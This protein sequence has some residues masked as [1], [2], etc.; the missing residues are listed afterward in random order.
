MSI[1]IFI[2]LSSKKLINQSKVL[3]TYCYVKVLVSFEMVI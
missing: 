2:Y 3:I 1:L